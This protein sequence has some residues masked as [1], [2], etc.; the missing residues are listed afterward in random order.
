M[1]GTSL[2]PRLAR[3]L[4]ESLKAQMHFD[5]RLATVLRTRADGAGLRRIQMRQLLD[6]L[7]TMPAEVRGDQIDAAYARLGEIGS[8]IPSA[9]RTSM[10]GDPALRLRSPRLVAALAESDPAVAQAALGRAQLNA[11][12]WFDLIPALSPGTRTALRQRGDLPPEVTTLLGR[13]GILDRGLPP[14]ENAAAPATPLATANDDQLEADPTASEGIG[15][16]VRRIEAYRRAKAV[17][18]Q[19]L[20]GDSPRLPL[21]E[22]HVLSVPAE[23]RA[24][25]F[26][27]DAQLRIVWCDAGVAPMLVGMQLKRGEAIEVLLRQRQPITAQRLELSGAPAISGAWQIDAVPWFDPLTGRFIGYRGRLRRPAPASPAPTPPV[28]S[29]PVADSASDRMRQMLHELRTPVNAIQG[30]AEVIQQQLFGPTPHEYRALAASIVGD[31][32]R[33]LSAFEELDRLARL[34]SRSLELDPGESDL[35]RLIEA[36]V[37]QLG[38]HTRKRSS[39]FNLRQDEAALPVAL[40]QL[41]LERIVWRLLATLAGTSAP[42]E[43]LKLRSRAKHGMARLDL[44]LPGSLAAIPDGALFETGVGAVPQI[45]S[46]GVFGVGFALRL[47][48]AEAQAAGGDLVRKGDRLKLTLPGLTGSPGGHSPGT[49][50][51]SHSA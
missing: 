15:A 38:A 19:P 4:P 10:L 7:G 6:L 24:A 35:A 22:D 16:I 21:G 17:V 44:A 13:L 1:L 46:A 40:G 50:V 37:T 30:F 47:A 3:T 12:Q 45:V 48:R 2:L 41:E 11:E 42:G 34:E 26:A 27:S 18:E 36:T 5:D 39:G 43:Q 33:M 32:A 23:V 29:A 9:E 31:A 49:E 51:A 28:P 14:A 8:Q 25:D 20:P